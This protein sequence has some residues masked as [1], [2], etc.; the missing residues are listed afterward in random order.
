MMMTMMTMLATMMVLS[1]LI[2]KRKELMDGL[3][4]RFDV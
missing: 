1:Q 2:V 3:E 4:R